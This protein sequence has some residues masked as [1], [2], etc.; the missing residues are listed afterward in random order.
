LPWFNPYNGEGTV[1]LDDYRKGK[2]PFATLLTT[3]DRYVRTVPVKGGFVDWNP[4]R[5]FITCP[6]TPEKEFVYH[7]KFNNGQEEAYEDVEQVVRR[8]DVIVCWN[9]QYKCWVFEKG[10][11]DELETAVRAIDE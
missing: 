9:S 8:C 7:D 4:Q 5:I 3:I 1:V 6:R 2:L 11:R 10:E